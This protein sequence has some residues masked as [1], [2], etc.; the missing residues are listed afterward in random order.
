MTKLT[1]NT[2]LIFDSDED[3]KRL[4]FMLECQRFAWN[5]CSKVKF[6]SVSKNSIV[7]LHT[8]FYTKFRIL[9]PEI[10]S[11]V[12]I[13]A[14]QSV[15][16][17]Y[18]S[19]KS[20]KHKIEKP[21]EKK[22]LCMRLDKRSYSYKNGTFSIINL[23][24]RVKC[25]PHLFPKLQEL[26]VRYKLCDP[27]IFEKNGEIWIALTFDVPE[28]P[29]KQTLVIG[30]DLGCRINAATSEGNLYV[31]IKFNKEKRKLRYLKRQ[32][33]SKS[34]KG[35]KSAKRHLKKLRHKE[36]NKNKNFSHNLAKKIIQ[37][38]KADT[39]AVENLKSIKVKK[40]K[41]QNKNRISQVP[42]YQ[43]KQILTHKALL[44]EK[45]VIE[46]SPSYTSQI[47]SVTGKRDG[48][49]QGRRYYSKSGKIY[50][51]DINAAVNIA[52]RSKLPVSLGIGND[53]KTYGQAKVNTPIVGRG[54]SASHNL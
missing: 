39:I 48:I 11:Q 1:Y 29:T 6:H 42:L 27:L 31:D 26:F 46:V 35:S 45:T 37:G 12:I 36:S 51:S 3:H 22:R 25:K 20:K 38:T 13:S 24:S 14:E 7:E 5:E 43:L 21:P 10:P 16:S 41:W 54:F 34:N 28:I 19:I 44:N 50:D 18:R 23:A 33:M 47:D 15:L 53:I 4:V 30:V 40:H 52:N 49:R 32:L 2:R 9:N 8:K 17:T